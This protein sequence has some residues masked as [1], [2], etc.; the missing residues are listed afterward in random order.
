VSVT[1]NAFEAVLSFVITGEFGVDVLE[2]DAL[3]E[4]LVEAGLLVEEEPPESI[5]ATGLNSMNIPCTGSPICT[6]VEQQ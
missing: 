3:I 2:L 4:C 1:T 6:K 5:S